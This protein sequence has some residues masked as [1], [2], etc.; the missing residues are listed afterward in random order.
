MQFFGDRLECCVYRHAGSYEETLYRDCFRYPSDIL[1][2]KCIDIETYHSKI[3]Q[4]IVYRIS[5]R[6]CIPDMWELTARHCHTVNAYD[7]IG[8]AIL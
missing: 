1:E 7:S 2:T 8:T 4:M 5:Q 6:Y 3:I